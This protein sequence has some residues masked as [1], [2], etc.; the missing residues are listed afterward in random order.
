[1]VLQSETLASIWGQSKPLQQITVGG[2]WGEKIVIKSDKSGNWACKLKTPKG[3]GPFA[4]K[5]TSKD[6][7]III[8]DV[9]IGEVW[10]ASGQS[11]MEMPLK[12]WP[13]KDPID[14]SDFEILNADFPTIRMF[15]VQKSYSDK[16]SKE[17]KGTWE[18]ALPPNVGSN[19]S[20]TAYFC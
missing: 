4:V 12:G 18:K 8:N 9:L 6:E 13:P 2:S 14:N 15:N 1:M 10:L 16:P 11:N 3:G 5:V 17:I 20:A 19:F 7:L